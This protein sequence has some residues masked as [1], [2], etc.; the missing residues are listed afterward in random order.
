MARKDESGLP[1]F[2]FDRRTETYWLQIGE[3]KRFVNLSSRN[4]KLHMQ[5]HGLDLRGLTGEMKTADRALVVAQIDRGVD[6]AG[7]LAGHPVGLFRTSGG[8]SILVTEEVKLASAAAGDCPRLEKFLAELLPGDQ[9]TYALFWLKIARQSLMERDFK[10]AQALC[11]F[12][13]S[14]CGKSLFQALVTEILG[15]RVGKPYQYMMGETAFNSDLCK[16]EHWCIEDE[17]AS[18]DIRAR[19]KFGQQMK[20]AAVNP[21]VRLHTKGKEGYTVTV[22]KRLTISANDEPENMMILPPLDDS[23]LDKVMLFKCSAAELTGDRKKDWASFKS[24]LPAFLALLDEMKIPA[25]M[26]CPQKRYGIRAFHHPDVLTVLSGVSPEE[27]LNSLIDETI[28]VKQG[29]CDRIWK[30]RAIELEKELRDSSFGFAVEKLLAFSS[31]AG[32]YLDRLSRKY[33][34]RFRATKTQGKTVWT[35][36][37]DQNDIQKD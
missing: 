37:S 11:L 5:F 33:P 35:I 25:G 12:G 16:C 19:R 17:S 32:T 24:E 14:G 4:A 28:F 10:P 26:R 36:K 23:I 30:G 7:P 22:Y 31:A 8:N 29:E 27:R 21:L 15:G 13:P 2:Y 18:F 3:E 9:H 20:E 34:D 1:A 6:Y